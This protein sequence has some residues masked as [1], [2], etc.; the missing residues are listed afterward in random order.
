[1]SEAKPRT[2]YEY[3]LNRQQFAEAAVQFFK[4]NGLLPA[5]GEFEMRIVGEPQSPMGAILSSQ[6]V[7][8]FWSLQFW[9][10]K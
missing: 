10:S 4:A 7:R 6:V 5:E 8:D 3:T 1:M 2:V 9:E